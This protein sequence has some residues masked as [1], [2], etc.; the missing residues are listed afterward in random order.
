MVAQM[1]DDLLKPEKLLFVRK[2]LE[3][4]DVQ[5]LA[6]L[7]KVPGD[8]NLRSANI[9][10][11]LPLLHEAREKDG[12]SFW[13]DLFFPWISIQRSVRAHHD[14]ILHEFARIGDFRL[15]RQEFLTHLVNIYRSIVSDLLDPYM[16]L[17]VACFQFMEGEFT[18]IK[19]A[20][21]GLGERNKAEFL[22]SRIGKV[23]PENRLLSGYEPIVRNAVTHPGSD[24]VIYRA[25]SVL[26]RNIKRGTP[27]GVEAVEWSQ[28]KLLN[29]I[30]CLYECIISIDAAVNVFGVDC[31]E[32]IVGNEDVKSEFIQ[33]AL[34]PERRAELRA[35][36]EEF[37]KRI[38]DDK[39]LTVNKRFE[40]LSQV[41]LN[42]CAVKKMEVRG[43]RVSIE[44]RTVMVEI[45]DSQEDLSNDEVLRDAVMGCAHY[46]ILTR[47]VFGLD[48][49]H[50]VVRTV[51][52]SGQSRLTV[53][54]AGKLLEQYIEEHAG[55]YDLLHEADVQLEGNKIVISVDFD[56]V[57]EN[58]R[59]SLDRLFPRKPRPGVHS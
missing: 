8:L 55:L 39:N 28:D 51:L 21:V 32:A 58:E 38:R 57:A 31:S 13:I 10:V 52:E 48:F 18:N 1:T 6:G 25:S 43:I 29:K 53:T 56:K 44:R 14:R 37:M 23:D 19:D 16:T 12:N 34:V 45:P 59:K 15:D 24:G 50:F 42:N 47:S 36:F 20:N 27:A 2:N 26:F 3:A 4:S 54:L 33:R 7:Q 22:E 30:I 17:P 41:L 46:A 40:L 49:D 5:K 11:L 35:P 9:S